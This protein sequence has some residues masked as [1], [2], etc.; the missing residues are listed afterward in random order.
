MHY[1]SITFE[2][3]KFVATGSD[4]RSL[5]FTVSAQGLTFVDKQVNNPGLTNNG[6][7]LVSNGSKMLVMGNKTWSS[8]DHG[9]TWKENRNMKL[10]QVKSALSTGKVWLAGTMFGKVLFSADGAKFE[11]GPSKLSDYP[12]QG[13]AQSGGQFFAVHQDADVL[14][15]SKDGKTWTKQPF[16]VQSEEAGLTMTFLTILGADVK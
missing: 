1:L 5:R 6:N 7:V 12:V 15:V 10:F 11:E 9:A 13:L 14:S 2:D 4:Q 3:G 16:K 8:D